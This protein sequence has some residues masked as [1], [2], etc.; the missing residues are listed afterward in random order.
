MNK[1]ILVHIK[2]IKKYKNL[3]LDISIK[4]DHLNIII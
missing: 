4:L 1:L 2:I 3:K